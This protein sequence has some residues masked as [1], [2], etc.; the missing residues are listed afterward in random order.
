M[1]VIRSVLALRQTTAHPEIA[2][3]ELSDRSCLAILE[4]MSNSSLHV[5]VWELGLSVHFALLSVVLSVFFPPLSFP[6]YLFLSVAFFFVYLYR[7]SVLS[8]FSGLAVCPSCLPVF[9]SLGV[10][11]LVM[12]QCCCSFQA[13]EC[14][15][16]D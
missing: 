3:A 14:E 10:L 1:V 7:L 15:C 6:T 8:I 12:N 4:H 5:Q 2:V 16:E 13:C 9:L 11:C